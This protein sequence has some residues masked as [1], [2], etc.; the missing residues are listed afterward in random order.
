MSN[1]GRV[2]EVREIVKGVE[3]NHTLSLIR[4]HDLDGLQILKWQKHFQSQSAFTHMAYGLT[5][6]FCYARTDVCQLDKVFYS[7]M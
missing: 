3:T 6:T 1:L 4:H 7:A 5:V 2:A